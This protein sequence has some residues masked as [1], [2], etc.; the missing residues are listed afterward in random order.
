[1]ALQEHAEKIIVLVEMMM[2]GSQDLPCFEKGEETVRIMKQNL[3]P[4]G[5]RRL[6][7]KDSLR[8]TDWLISQSV[9]NWRTIWY[10]R[11]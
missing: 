9:N 10:D 3:F 5:G 11:V 4:D 6:S 8:Y 1:M 2:L 7:K